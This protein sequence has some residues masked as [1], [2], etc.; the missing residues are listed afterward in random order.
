METIHF[1]IDE[2]TKQLAM[3]AA[4]RQ[5]T[6]LTKLMREK[7]E[8]LA[9]Q[10]R[11]YQSNAHEYWLE[12]QIAEAIERYDGGQTQAINHSESQQRMR[13]L[14]QRLIEKDSA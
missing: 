4:K 11:E 14:R 7:A 10:E 5:N 1:R 3:Q 9:A 12:A 2:K 13:Q 6:D 8:E